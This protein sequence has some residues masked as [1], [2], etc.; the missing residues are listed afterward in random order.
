MKKKIVIIGGGFAGS[1]AAKHLEKKFDVTLI[2]TKDYFEFTPGILRSIVEPEHVKKIQVL[3]S[4]YL[5]K[6][7][8]LIG[9]V[10][11]ITNSYVLF[12]N[13]KIKFDYLVISSGSTYNA[14]FKEPNIITATRASHLREKYEK[15]CKAKRILIIGGGLVGVEL[16]GEICDSYN[17]KQ[18]TI[19]HSKEKLIE[20][21]NEKAIRYA[22]KYLTKKGVKFILKEK[23]EKIKGKICFTN[24]GTCI[25]SDMIFLCTGIKPNYKLMEKNFS[26]SLNERNQIKVNDYLQVFGTKHIFAAGDITGINEEKTAQNAERQ[27][28][29]II[30]NI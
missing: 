30:H 16:A 11:E 24:Q 17:D 5:K 23:V 29:T 22:Q 19:A 21:N 10:K 3:H 6:A 9:T 15:L 14:P 1:H 2:D 7:K 27:A 8:I 20:R 26:N 13:K 12:K 18:I 4:H 28:E 25:E